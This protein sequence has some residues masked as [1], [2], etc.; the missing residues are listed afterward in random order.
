M[1][2]EHVAVP[3]NEFSRGIQSGVALD[4][5]AVVVVKHMLSCLRVDWWCKR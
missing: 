2:K 3:L 4:S 1:V 5:G